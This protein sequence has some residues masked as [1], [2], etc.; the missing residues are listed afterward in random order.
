MVYRL[1]AD[2]TITKVEGAGG[3]TPSDASDA[4]RKREVQYAYSWFKNIT[5]DTFG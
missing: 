3:L 1:G 4:M 5:H 2:G